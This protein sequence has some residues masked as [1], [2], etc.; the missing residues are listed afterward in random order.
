MDPF[1]QQPLL[2][3]WHR[4]G[5]ASAFLELSLANDCSRIAP[6]CKAFSIPNTNTGAPVKADVDLPRQLKDQVLVFKYKGK[7]H[8]IDHQC[9]HLSFPLS[10]GSLFDIEDFVY[11]SQCLTHFS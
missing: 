2:A 7:I 10:P 1:I 3:A 8:A 6:S 5:L 4:I 11:C 9:P